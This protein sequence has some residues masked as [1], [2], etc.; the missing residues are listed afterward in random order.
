ML[1]HFYLRKDVNV[2]KKIIIVVLLISVLASLLIIPSYAGTPSTT[3]DI[4]TTTVAEDLATMSPEGMTFEK[5]EDRKS[6]RLNSS[7]C[8]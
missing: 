4:T 8:L 1:L 3:R 5:S 2:I 7:H 6:T